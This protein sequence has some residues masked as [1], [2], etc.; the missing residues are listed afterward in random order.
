[1]KKLHPPLDAKEGTKSI[2][3]YLKQLVNALLKHTFLIVIAILFI[4]LIMQTTFIVV[5]FDII[6]LSIYLYTHL[7]KISLQLI[8]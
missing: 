5:Y 6:F 2:I 4:K 7:L 8:F 3:S 1:M